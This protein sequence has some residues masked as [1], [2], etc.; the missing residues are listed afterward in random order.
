MMN[1]DLQRAARQ[2]PLAVVLVTVYTAIGGVLSIVVSVVLMMAGSAASQWL[3]LL[4]ALFLVTGT[5][6][7]AACYG[8]WML[9][10]WGHTLVTILYAISIP[11]ALL[12]LAAGKPGVGDVVLQV[13]GIGIAI[14]I[15]IWL[16]NPT[17]KGLYCKGLREAVGQKGTLEPP[18]PSPA[19][20]ATKSAYCTECGAKLDVGVRF[21]ASCG[22]K[23]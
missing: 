23:V 8:L 13:V 3:P 14:W 5:L 9:L 7:I 12:L 21:C 6:S 10:P 4:G 22:A 16:H 1:S 17:T 18:K 20:A 2:R 15:L 11:L 19:S